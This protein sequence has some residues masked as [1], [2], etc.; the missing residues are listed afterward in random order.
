M[1]SNSDVQI[2]VVE[3]D[4]SIRGLI[5]MALSDEGYEVMT[6]PHGA[7]ALDLIQ[8]SA[9]DFI[10]LDMSMPVMDGW[11]FSRAYRETPGR[12]APIVALTAAHNAAN[13]AAEI[14]AAGYLAKPFTLDVLLSMVDHHAAKNHSAR[15]R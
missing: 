10:L 4:G 14:Q 3:D 7:A 12:H 13:P 11:E 6:A 8:E 5:E 1:N 9:P 15:L 2:L